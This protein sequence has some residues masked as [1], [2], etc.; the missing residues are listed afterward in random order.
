MLSALVAAAATPAPQKAPAPKPE[1][2]KPSEEA[3]AAGTGLP[4][5]VGVG[6]SIAVAVAAF[7]A[8]GKNQGE[9]RAAEEQLKEGAQS[10]AQST[11]DLAKG[12]S[13]LFGFRR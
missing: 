12:G 6:G 1:K 8:N 10:A 2:P 13:G 9:V 7:V 5:W 4:V 3:A 11:A